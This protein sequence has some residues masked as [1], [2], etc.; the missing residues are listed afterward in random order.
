GEA[1]I[2]TY[3]NFIPFRFHTTQVSC[4]WRGSEIGR[5]SPRSSGNNNI[6]TIFGKVVK[7]N[8]NQVFKQA[9]FST[10]VEFLGFFPMDVWVPYDLLLIEVIRAPFIGVRI[11]KC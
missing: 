8:G 5:D 11:E 6:G 2:Q 7:V 9:D 1:F 3:L 10:V 4:R